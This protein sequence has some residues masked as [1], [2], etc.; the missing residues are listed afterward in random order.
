M[1]I[2]SRRIAAVLMLKGKIN[3]VRTRGWPRMNWIDA[4]IE[5]TFVKAYIERKRIAQNKNCWR[6]FA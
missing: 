5:W 2:E 4:V 1:S 3:G 6:N